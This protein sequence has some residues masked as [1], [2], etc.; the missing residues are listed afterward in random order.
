V[1]VLDV[2]MPR[3]SGPEAAMLISAKR[4]DLPFVLCS[5]FPGML[6][7]TFEL[8]P[9]WRWLV[10]PYPKDE[11]IRTIQELSDQRK[12]RVGTRRTPAA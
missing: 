5:G 6:R 1:A 12:G 4:P 8:K 11:L 9:N 3:M 10:K 2:V 7:D